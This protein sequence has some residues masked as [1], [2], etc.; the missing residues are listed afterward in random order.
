MLHKFVVTLRQV[1]GPT[2]FQSYLMSLQR[3]RYAGVPS[4]EEAR[5]DYANSVRNFTTIP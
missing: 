3:N 2:P 5:R 1:T 4:I